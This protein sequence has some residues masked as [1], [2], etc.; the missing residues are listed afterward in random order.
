MLLQLHT[1]RVVGYT[2]GQRPIIYLKTTA[3]I[4]AQ[5]GVSFVF[6]DGHGIARY[7]EWFD[8]LE[9]LDS[10]DWGMV[11][12]RY[13]SDTMD[14]MDRQRRKQAEFLIHRFCDWSLIQE[15]AVMDSGMKE[16]VIGILGTYPPEMLRE[17]KIRREW[18]YH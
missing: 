15:I 6:S 11:N 9:N 8:S 2:E 3:Q 1:N 5:S 17:V 12:Q 7:T 10:V 18:Y 13:W 4:A 16:K 14:D